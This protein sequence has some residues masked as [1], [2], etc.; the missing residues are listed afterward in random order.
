MQLESNKT[1]QPDDYPCQNMS[2]GLWHCLEGGC[3]DNSMRMCKADP[4]LGSPGRELCLLSL[5]DDTFYKRCVGLG[6]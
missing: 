5:E 4:E 2:K 6:F 1:N 3:S